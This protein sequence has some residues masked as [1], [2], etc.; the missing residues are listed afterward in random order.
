MALEIFKLVGSVMVDTNEANKSLAKTDEHAEKA[1]N[2][3]LKAA[4]KAAKW[5][6]GLVAAAGAVGGAMIASARATASNLDEIDKA[7]QRMEMDAE[8]YQKLAYAADLCGVNTSQLEAASK[9]LKAN[10]GDDA[11]LN[12]Y[13]IMLAN[14]EDVTARNE[15][16]TELF[17]GAVAQDLIPMLNA[18]G[19]GLEAM[20]QEAEDL[21]VVMSNDAVKAGADMNDAFSKVD[22]ML[23]TVK[24]TIGTALLPIIQQLLDWI[25][26]H[27]P[28]IQEFAQKTAEVVTDVTK[29]IAK[30]IE[31]IWPVVEKVFNKIKD[32]WNNVLKP[33]FTGIIQFLEGVFTGNWRKVFEGLA[34]IVKGI[35][36][37]IVETVK[38]PINAIIGLIN[39]AIRGFN[40]IKIPDWVP[41]VGGK[42]INIPE[43]P[44]LAKGGDIAESG[45][46]LVGE[47]GP[48]LLNLPTGARV[49]PLDKAQP[50][51]YDTLRKAIVDGMREIIPM[52]PVYNLK[53]DPNG[54]F[55][56]VKEQNYENIMNG[57]EGILV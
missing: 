47:R 17:G 38:I 40:N 35:F 46:V 29:K 9:K 28:E 18:G 41:G 21:G 30:A 14:M 31:T 13:L 1:G 53:P 25:I 57:R 2:S 43:I 50:I 54:I 7:S 33:V 22:R 49:T 52:M 8:S 27:A 45:T 36:N 23:D 39:G 3:L 11:D 56:L 26:A 12:E 16:A 15:L 19:D 44:L 37:G 6:A 34:N 20:Q 42:G 4:E 5:A 51:D 24:A 55:E 10:M 48:E 32:I